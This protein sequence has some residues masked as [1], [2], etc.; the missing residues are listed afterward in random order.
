MLILAVMHP[1]FTCLQELL[2]TFLLGA[3][4][5]MK[6][7]LPHLLPLAHVQP[8]ACCLTWESVFR[9]WDWVLPAYLGLRGRSLACHGGRR[10]VQQPFVFGPAEGRPARWVAARH[11]SRLC[12][13]E[14]LSFYCCCPWGV[15]ICHHFDL[16]VS[17]GFPERDSAFFIGPGILRVLCF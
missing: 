6:A 5:G 1:N 3:P 10:D 15:A 16:A 4:K 17:I 9:G 2:G 8:P 7:A 14:L 11:C 12:R 13:S